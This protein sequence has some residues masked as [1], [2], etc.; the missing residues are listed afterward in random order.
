[1]ALTCFLQEFSSVPSL[2]PFLAGLSSQ[3]LAQAHT[4]PPIHNSRNSICVV[5]PKN[6]G[7]RQ[8]T[9]FQILQGPRCRRGHQYVI[10]GAPVTTSWLWFVS[11]VGLPHTTW[12]GKRLLQLN[13][14]LKPPW[15]LCVKRLAFSSNVTTHFPWDF[16]QVISSLWPSVISPVSGHGD[17]GTC[18]PCQN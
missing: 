14:S 6:K 17:S 8:I 4:S 11:N 16:G 18:R 13:G 9:G 10:R 15:W 12:L 5:I 3:L 1:M 7:P 2:P